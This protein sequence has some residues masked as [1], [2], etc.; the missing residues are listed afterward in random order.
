M[1]DESNLHSLIT[2]ETQRRNVPLGKLL[3]ES[4]QAAA[5]EKLTVRADS[6]LSPDWREKLRGLA[7]VAEAQSDWH[8][9]SKPPWSELKLLLVKESEFL[10]WL[11]GATGV[12]KH[13]T[14][15]PAANVGAT[16]PALK[17]APES[18]IDE[19]INAE[20]DTAEQKGLK[21]PN[22]KEIVALVQPRL[23]AQGFNASGRQIQQVADADKHKSRRRQPGRTVASE[24]RGNP[25]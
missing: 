20:Y 12:T 19:A 16:S 4:L 14:E 10:A 15:V 1:F 3:R 9:W 5:N 23:R 13:A 25:R 24:K 2:R 11:D 21:A 7:A 6:G 8:W 17:P 22:V 18:K